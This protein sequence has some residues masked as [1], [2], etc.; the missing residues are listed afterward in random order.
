M[1]KVLTL[2]WILL[3]LT[4]AASESRAEPLAGPPSPGGGTIP[5]AVVLDD[6]PVSTV[7]L[8]RFPYFVLP[9]GYQPMNPPKTRDFGHFPFWTGT[10]LHDVDGKVFLSLI[11]TE[12]GKT[13]SSYELKKNIEAVLTQAGGRKLA[14]SKIPAA[15]TD[16]LPEEVTMGMYDGL[17]DVFNEPTQTWVIRRPDKQIWVHF[18][19]GSNSASWTILETKPFAQTASLLPADQLKQDIDKTGR[20]VIHVNFATDKTEILPDSAAQIEAVTSLLKTNP[21]L[22]LAING[23]TD[24]TGSA[25]HNQSLSDGRARAVMARLIASGVAKDRLR[26][27]GFGAASPV[28][29]NGSEEGRAKNRRVELVKF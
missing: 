10:A 6:I 29:S 19:P 23:Y 3:A 12:D 27:K 26:A 22:K 14:D 24:E 20:A 25:G 11:S 2:A 21:G 28:A 4:W 17:G 9:A 16:T 8:G 1:M 13:Y 15:M 7:P 5:G 18:V